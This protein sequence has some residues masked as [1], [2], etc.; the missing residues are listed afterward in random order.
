MFNVITAI[1]MEEKNFDPPSHN[2]LYSF[3]QRIFGKYF[4]K[5][6]LEN[7]LSKNIWRVI[8]MLLITGGWSRCWGGK[9]YQAQTSLII[10]LLIILMIILIL[11]IILNILVMIITLIT[12]PLH[13][14]SYTWMRGAVRLASI[15]PT[16]H[17]PATSMPWKRI[18]I[19]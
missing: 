5:E 18:L 6:Y 7:I 12:P 14:W 4:V 10:I 8:T 2:I 19:W 11:L 15:S 3:H 13:S 9:F 16:P 1:I 17:R